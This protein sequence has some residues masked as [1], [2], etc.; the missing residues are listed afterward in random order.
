[1]K[2]TKS[3]IKDIRLKPNQMYMRNPNLKGEGVQ[4]AYTKEMV[5]ER[6]KCRENPEYFIRTYIKIVHVDHGLVDFNLWPYQEKMVWT[7]ARNRFIICKLPR[8]SGKSTTVIGYMIWKMIFDDSQSIAVLANKG[9]LAQDLLG[10]FALAYEHL[11]KW[12]QQG[13]VTWNKRSIE[14]ENRSKIIAAATSS[15]AARGGSYNVILLDEFAHVQRNQAEAF[16]TSVYPT[17]SSGKETQVIIVSTPL[18]L[19]HFY[20][21]WQDAVDKKSDYV[22]IEVHWRETPGRDDAWRDEQIRNTSEEQFKQEFDTEFLGS[23]NTLINAEV[24]RNMVYKEATRDKNG[25]DIYVPPVKGH[26]YVIT[27]DTA[28]GVELDSS[29]FSVIDVTA[30]PYVQV[31]KYKS[32]TIPVIL[33]PEVIS[34]YGDWYNTAYVLVENNDV[35]LQVASTLHLDIEYENV[36][37][38]IMQ[39]R[40]GQKIGGGFAGKS[41][42]GVK[43][44]PAVKRIGCSNLKDLIES[45]K[46]M[47]MDF[48][49]INELSTFVAKKKSFEAEE[50]CH[51]DVVMSLVLFGWLARQPYFRDLTNSDVRL[52]MIQ[53]NMK[54]Q[55]DDLLPPG[56]MDD[57]SPEPTQFDKP[58]PMHGGF[59]DF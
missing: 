54:E 32:N 46:L 31:A 37:S 27:V 58:P 39:G 53:E 44:S 14:L 43:M 22:P 15:S 42:L 23:V 6:K 36:L 13:A 25:V 1:M 10:K 2:L 50:G 24:L 11:P 48:D 8:Q 56:F 41:A 55:F 20:K 28:R 19:N 29:A 4:I 7:F 40:S 35:G 59:T 57:G 26:T 5:E 45:E 12:L 38:T 16:F 9:Q 30:I 52:R 17:I 34:H 21:R 47:T 33:F 3:P 18:G 49:T 51:D